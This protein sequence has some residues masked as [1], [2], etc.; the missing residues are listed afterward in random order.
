[1]AGA[2][3][4]ALTRD[5]ATTLAV[6][7]ALGLG[8]AFPYLALSAVPALQRR[9]PRPGPWMVRFRQLMAFP[10]LVT[11]AWLVW[12]LAQQTDAQALLL[13]LMGFVAIGFALWAFQ[14]VGRLAQAGGIAALALALALGTLPATLSSQ[15]PASQATATGAGDAAESTMAGA[16]APAERFSPE[17]L[18]ELR[19][20]GRPVF[21]NMTAAWCLTCIVN[22]KTVLDGAAFAATLAR[23]DAVYMKGDWTRRDPA[24]TA[25]LASFARAG[26]PLYVVYPA[27]GEPV[28][29]PQILTGDLVENAFAAAAGDTA[30]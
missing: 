26:V 30:S 20:T 3:G 1:M 11:A 21:V 7:A 28:I 29:L 9:L 19:A 14:Q 10:M 27:T 15:A 18:A 24:I 8:L 23:H 17:R 2:I 13:V 22:E 6:F 25:Y 16:S 5:A 12:V 4:F